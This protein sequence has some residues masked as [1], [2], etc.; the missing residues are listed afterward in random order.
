MN[1]IGIQ[2]GHMEFQICSSLVV[3]VLLVLITYYVYKKVK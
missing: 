2:T 3:L 1:S